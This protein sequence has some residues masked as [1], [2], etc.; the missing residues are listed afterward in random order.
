MYAL[1]LTPYRALANSEDKSSYTPPRDDGTLTRN[2][3]NTNMKQCPPLSR[4]F[5]NETDRCSSKSLL[6]SD[7]S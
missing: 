4:I 6:N 3:N 1:E 2:I 7:F 5:Y